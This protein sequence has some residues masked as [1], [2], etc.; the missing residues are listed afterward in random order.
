MSEAGGQK[1]KQTLI[2]MVKIAYTL[3]GKGKGRK[4]ELSELLEIIDNK[5]A[6]FDKIN[7]NKDIDL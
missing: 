1:D 2:E 5:T 4:R 6:Y 7:I 3:I